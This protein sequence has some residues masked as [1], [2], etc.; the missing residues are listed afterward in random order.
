MDPRLLA[1]GLLGAIGVHEFGA[2]WERSER[3]RELITLAETRARALNRPLVVVRPEKSG[4]LAR[5]IETW[6]TGIVEP[7][8]FELARAEE[9][10]RPPI[11]RYQDD[12]AVVF[13][14][15]V[16]EFLE[17]VRPAMDEILRIAGSVENIYVV[18]LQPWTFWAQLHPRARWVGLSDGQ[19]V[20]LGRITPVQRGIAAGVLIGLAGLSLWPRAKP[21]IVGPP[22]PPI[23]KPTR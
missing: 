20:S 15:C 6:E 3:R 21:E 10:T 23:P 16:L 22:S 7:I 11:R 4:P 13:V 8:T 2:L 9:F 1:Q 19:V 18:T 12:S 17:D 14:A 5:V